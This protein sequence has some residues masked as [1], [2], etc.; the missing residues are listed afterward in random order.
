MTEDSDDLVAELPDIS[1]LD[2]DQVASLANP[3]LAMLLSRFLADRS[4]SDAQW[5][6]FQDGS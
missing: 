6:G 4:G 2:L 5:V 1:S 3:M